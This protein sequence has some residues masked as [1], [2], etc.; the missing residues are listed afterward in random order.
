MISTD[1]SKDSEILMK[2]CKKSKPAKNNFLKKSL[3]IKLLTHS[4]A[5]VTLKD[6]ASNIF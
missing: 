6:K 4:L 2:G 3:V 5:K 1:N